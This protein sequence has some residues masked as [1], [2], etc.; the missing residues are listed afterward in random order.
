MTLTDLWGR[1]E[2]MT[3]LPQPIDDSFLVGGRERRDIVLVDYD[4][5]WPER[6]EA[7][8]TKVEGPWGRWH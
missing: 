7:E 6:F 2:R 8:R 1:L 4:P 5:S 3:D